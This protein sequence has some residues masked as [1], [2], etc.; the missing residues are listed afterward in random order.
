MTDAVVNPVPE[1]ALPPQPNPRPKRQGSAGSFNSYVSPLDRAQ[2]HS[3]SEN[4]SSALSG[5][6][7]NSPSA[8]GMTNGSQSVSGYNFYQVLAPH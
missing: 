3:S 8:A 7:L 2:Q 5:D 6:S 4:S 1:Q